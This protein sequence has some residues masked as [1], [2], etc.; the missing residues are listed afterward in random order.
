MQ[1]TAAPVGNRPATR[2]IGIVVSRSLVDLEKYGSLIHETVHVSKNRHL[3]VETPVRKEF[4]KLPGE[5]SESKEVGFI[6][7]DLGE[8]QQG[9]KREAVLV[10]R[11]GFHNELR[12]K[13]VRHQDYMYLMAQMAVEGIITTAASEGIQQPKR[14]LA[15]GD[16]IVVSDTSPFYVMQ[17]DGK[18]TAHQSGGR[19]RSPKYDR[20][21]SNLLVAAGDSAEIVVKHS[22][23]NGYV[24]GYNTTEYHPAKPAVEYYK[25]C[26]ISL[27]NKSAVV[28]EDLA[29]SFGIPIA[30]LGIVARFAE[31]EEGSHLTR[32][33][34]DMVVGPAV[35]NAETLIFTAAHIWA[36]GSPTEKAMNAAGL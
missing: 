34:R 32:M 3:Q 22:E 6:L 28:E 19:Y 31:G 10:Q 18:Y 27:L 33:D 8:D 26:G 30:T 1:H 13:M 15:L 7:Y 17:L 2:R 20:E 25:Q 35:L 12:S 9:N 24:I 5:D 36:R 11:H 29:T 23:S 16:L 14:E 21:L 4:V